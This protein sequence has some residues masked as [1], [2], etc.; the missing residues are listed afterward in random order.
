MDLKLF[1]Q[2]LPGAILSAL[3]SVAII[4]ALLLMTATEE[5]VDDFKVTIEY[6]CRAVIMKP[7]GFPEQ[8]IEECRNKIRFLTEPTKQ[9]QSV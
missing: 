7:T 3:F 1:K 6:D 5:I 9:S 8:V 2:A 4:V